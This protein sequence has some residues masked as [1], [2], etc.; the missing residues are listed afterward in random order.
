MAKAADAAG[1]DLLSVTDH[2]AMGESLKG[3]PYGE[4]PTKMDF[5]WFEPISVLSAMAAATSASA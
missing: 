1:I 5:D 2:V 4:F 3:Y